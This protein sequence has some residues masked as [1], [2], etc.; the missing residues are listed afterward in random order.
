MSFRCKDCNIA[1]GTYERPTK[2]VIERRTKIVR[3]PNEDSPNE[4]HNE[5][6]DDC[7]HEERELCPSCAFKRQPENPEVIGRLRERAAEIAPT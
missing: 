5:T 1:L 2:L 4:Y 3:V 7:I 6:I